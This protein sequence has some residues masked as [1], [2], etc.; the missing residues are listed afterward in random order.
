[1]KCLFLWKIRGSS[2]F[3][4]FSNTFPDKECSSRSV[5]Q[6]CSKTTKLQEQDHLF[7]SRPRPVRPRPRPLF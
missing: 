2:L 7:F 6:W 3:S 5:E 4:L 1:M